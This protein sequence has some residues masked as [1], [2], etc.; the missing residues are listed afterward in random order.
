MLYLQATKK[1]IAALG[2]D[3][4]SLGP[5]SESTAPLGNWIIN[6]IPIGNRQAYLFVNCK[7]LLSFPILI[8]KH[9]PVLQ[10]LPQFLNHGLV[11]LIN[12]LNLSTRNTE[13]ATM[14][15]DR[16]AFCVAED[17]S[18]LGVIR[19]L[20]TDYEH[21]T[22]LSNDLQGRSLGSII[23]AINS[24]PRATLNYKTSAEK[25]LEVLDAGEA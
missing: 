2:L 8:G 18:L 5:S 23:P 16:I 10:D 14:S 6:L 7:T 11:Q 15:L 22:Q 25:A 3:P 17:R 9:K 12:W 21:R 20:A 24:T 13:L 1:A 4:A 19:S